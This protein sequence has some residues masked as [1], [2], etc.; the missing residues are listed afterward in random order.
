M[1]PEALAIVSTLLGK[2][3]LCWITEKN[4]VVAKQCDSDLKSAIRKYQIML[5]LKR[6]SCRHSSKENRGDV[7]SIHI[8][9]SNKKRC[10]RCLQSTAWGFADS[11][12]F[13]PCRSLTR[14]GKAGPCSARV[15]CKTA[16]CSWRSS[17][18]IALE[19]R[20]VWRSGARSHGSAL[21]RVGHCCTEV[22]L[23]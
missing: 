18:C 3:V 23:L 19:A 15:F 17:G 12:E 11:R 20:G 22:A 1:K 9:W 5:T 14:E 21:E 7:I 10:Y 8:S 16:F 4:P 2:V 6:I 13:L